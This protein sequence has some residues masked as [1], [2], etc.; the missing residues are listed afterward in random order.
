MAGGQLEGRIVL[1]TGASRG[2]GAAVARRF[3]AEGARL[4]LV[5]RTTGGLE[6]V[7]D[8]VRRISGERATL[9]PLDLTD[10]AGIDT[11]GAALYAR[12]GQSLALFRCGFAGVTHIHARISRIPVHRRISPCPRNRLVAF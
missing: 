3:A 9:V 7:D 2:I 1:I 6:E 4:I 8:E 11:L 5:A 12:F 10:S